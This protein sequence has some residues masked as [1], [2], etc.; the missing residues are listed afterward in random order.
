MRNNFLTF[1]F[2]F[3]LI[4]ANIHAQWIKVPINKPEVKYIPNYIY[5]IYS[6][7]FATEQKAFAV[8]GQYNGALYATTDSGINWDSIPPY[9]LIANYIYF[10][11][12]L[13]GYIAGY[14]F[15]LRTIDGGQTWFD[16]SPDSSISFYNYHYIT[17][18]SSGRIWI[19]AL[20]ADFV[21]CYLPDSQIYH[22]IYLSYSPLDEKLKTID[23]IL[24]TSAERGYLIGSRDANSLKTTL[25]TTIDSGKIW[26]LVHNLDDIEYFRDIVFFNDS[27][28]YGTDGHNIYVTTNYGLNWSKMFNNDPFSLNSPKANNTGTY[29]PS[30][31]FVNED[32]GYVWGASQIYRTTNGGNTWEKTNLALDNGQSP[33]LTRIVCSTGNHCFAGTEYGKIYYTFNGGG[34]LT[35]IKTEYSTGTDKLEI[36]PNPSSGK[37]IIY[38]PVTNT[39]V[40]FWIYDLTGRTV[41]SEKYFNLNTSTFTLDISGNPPGLYLIELQTPKH[42]WYG[43]VMLE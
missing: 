7:A 4:I 41:F 24:F 39:E 13:Q 19:S 31:F 29:Y 5:P 2:I 8:I 21:Y 36:Y 16:I 10:L 32:T 20:H 40:T 23:K 9:S 3:L 26:T 15:I 37:L 22:R 35:G 27:L 43:K 33:E 1:A 17:A 11:D 12:S 14:N 30:L 6:I 28:A 25:Y 18:D 42:T 38:L 34:V